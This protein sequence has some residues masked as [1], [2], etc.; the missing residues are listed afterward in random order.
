MTAHV[1][2]LVAGAGISGLVC[3]YALRK[4]GIDARI[5]ESAAVPGGVI[6]S[7]RREAYL[8]EFGP[9]S[10]NAS[11]AVLKLCRELHIEDR[12]VQ[13]PPK[14][15]RFVL[16]NGKL[17]RVPLTPPALLSS[18]LFSSKSKMR[19][20]RDFLGHST[21]PEN[22]ESVAAFVRR[23]FSPEVLE[24]LV[25]PFVSGIYA[26][27]PEKLS[28]RGAFPQLHEAERSSG[29]VIR[30]M[31]R[32][33]KMNGAASAKPTL[34]TFRDGN[35]TL[36]AALA[37]NLGASLRCGVEVRAARIAPE[38][39]AGPVFEVTAIA[40]GREEIIKTERLIIATPSLQ[41]SSLLRGIDPQFEPSLK[42]I[43]Y[44]PVAV[45]SLGYALTSIRHSLDGFGFLVP[46]SS[47][48]RILGTVW[49]TSL[50]SN[51]A[52][53]GHAL[54]TSFLGGATDPQA[55]S[56]SESQLVSNVHRELA[57]ILGISQEPLFSS[58]WTYDR[59]I[60]QFNIGHAE[61]MNFLTELQSKYPRLWLAGNY[62]RGPSLAVC[63]EQA[64]TI[65]QQVGKS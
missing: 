40:N 47:G 51:R 13:A 4:A 10:F 42:R 48:L 23:K 15:P 32:A 18:S 35:Q 45:V 53:Q 46:R 55:I 59:A 44:A 6:R 58:V 62:W 20:L 60:P 52:P 57:A 26:G 43:E 61:T 14:A 12:L 1:P 56:L 41:A 11:A 38:T 63:I 30:G 3:A 37:A 50:F 64:L 9:Q 39:A 49:N 28:L 29:S 33:G 7:E 31:L 65:A 22:D 21:P 25:G 54:L 34:Q 19:V 36:I 5:V 24:K 16:I 8:L 2:A 27:D 17:L